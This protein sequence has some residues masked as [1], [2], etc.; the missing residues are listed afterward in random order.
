MAIY[1]M[2][3]GA[4][5]N[6]RANVIVRI[7]LLA[8]LAWCMGINPTMAQNRNAGEIRGTVTDQSGA[9][10]PGVVVTLRNVQTGVTNHVM[11]DSS[12]VYDAVSVSSGLYSVA[13]TKQGFREFVRANIVLGVQ[14]LTINAELEVGTVSQ[15]VTVKAPTPLLQTESSEENLT[16]DS[17]AL[18]DLPSSG[19][20]WMNYTELIPGVNGGGGQNASGSTVGVNGTQ[21]YQASWLTDGG[22]AQ[23]A[24]TPDPDMVLPIESIS[25]VSFDVHNFGAD[26]GNGQTSFNVIT[27][28][29]TNQWHGSLYEFV[30]NDALGGTRNYFASTVTPVRWN[31]FGGTVGG[32][33]MRN[34]A[35][36]F[37]SMQ[38]N[39]NLSYAPGFYTYPTAAARTGDFSAPGYPTIYDPNTLVFVNG[40]YVETPVPGNK[41]PQSEIDPV[42]AAIQKYYPMP[43]LPGLFNN[44]FYE[45]RQR[46]DTSIYAGKVD[47]NITSGNS[48]EGS[49]GV[50]KALQNLSKNQPSCP[51]LSS[52][53][54]SCQNI[55]TNNYTGQL[56]DVWTFS[57]TKVNVARVAVQRESQESL[58]P[59]LNKGY[60]NKMGLQNCPL[61]VFPD[62]YPSGAIPVSGLVGG[63]SLHNPDQT[64]VTSDVF[65]WTKGKHLLKFGGELDK[66][67]SNFL[68]DWAHSGDMYFTGV[69]TRN[70]SDPT[71]TGLGYA[72]ML[73]G[74]PQSWNVHTNPEM[75]HRLWSL[76]SF[77]Q[78][79][80]KVERNLT[81][82]L[83]VRY[84][85]QPGWTEV[86]NEMSSFDPTILNT[87]TNTLGAM[88]FSPANGRRSLE[89][90]LG[91]LFAPRV[92]FSWSPRNSWIVR[93]GYGIY[94]IQRNASTYALGGYQVGYGFQGAEVSTDS[95]HPIFQLK[96]GLPSPIYPT[97]ATR[98]PELENY[99]SP[100][101]VP[102]H[103][104]MGYAEDWQL[105]VQHEMP[106]G[107]LLD[108]GYVET[109]G[110]HLN[111][112][113]DADQ[114]Q[115]QYLHNFATS[116]TNMQ[117]YRPYPIYYGINA[118]YMDGM[119]NYNALQFTVRKRMSS[120]VSFL[121]NYAWSKAMDRGTGSGWSLGID[122]YQNGWDPRSNYGLA[123][124]D[125]TNMFN[126][127]VVYQ[128][129]FGAE[130]QFLN[131]RG[132]TDVV[133]GGWQISSI[134]QFHSGI[135][136]TPVIGT[137]NLDGSLAG[138]WYP[139]RVGSGKLS[140]PTIQEWFDPTAFTTPAIGTFGNSGRDILRGPGWQKV[141]LSLA[142]GF[143]VPKAGEKAK[144]D[145]RI[146]AFDAFNHPNFGMP[147]AAIGTAGVGVISS[148]NTNRTLQAGATFRF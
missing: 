62:F 53:S 56:T 134:F 33:I 48:L 101:Y 47:Y 78:D 39:P 140:H 49:F 105:D 102:Y 106:G 84:Q 59:T 142:K 46:A 107:I 2:I 138:A 115:P 41:I 44:Y 20:N 13:F 5:R 109:G 43:N 132:I 30:Q 147:D 63:L 111:N 143:A 118:A 67:Q 14:S 69:F 22:T 144:V 124:L 37:F 82:N 8:V 145:F 15:V 89:A 114:V 24:L 104:P 146:D 139:N 81:L 19:E 52:W 83:G 3:Q 100:T 121:A 93:G 55:T 77:V 117:P 72:D 76:Q 141:D 64:V 95:V 94:Y 27:K 6:A 32:P 11:T 127:D 133:L 79:D 135:P 122:T 128:L 28:S 96:N 9:I 50:S 71:S 92:G 31:L 116:G 75:G 90:T 23:H 123:K 68:W 36:F 136:F 26:S 87:A 7:A 34:K 113:R 25:E 97:A 112:T 65:N 131:R 129:P 148:A 125:M 126:G 86:H 85:Y 88:W 42:A 73:F 108:L 10:I 35:F 91:D 1:Q 130:R 98:T 45:G 58:P 12:G 16:L 40:Q 38:R 54:W 18:T 57:S 120:G 110:F 51:I 17:Q 99:Q 80:Y 119:S 29:G 60:C 4:T 66:W 21:E 70:P 74:L 137:A 103:T 61:D